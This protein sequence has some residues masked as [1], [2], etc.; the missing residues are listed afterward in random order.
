MKILSVKTV[1]KTTV[2][3]ITAFIGLQNTVLA[4]SGSTHVFP[5]EKQLSVSSLFQKTSTNGEV[6]IQLAQRRLGSGSRI[7]PACDD[8]DDTCRHRIH[9]YMS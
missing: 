3:A 1:L 5:L 6:T 8:G 4:A 9:D 2:F 7:N